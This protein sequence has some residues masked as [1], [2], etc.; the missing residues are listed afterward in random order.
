MRN[1]NKNILSAVDTSSQNGQQVDASQ[2][3]AA[4]FAAYF[5]DASANGTVKI[6]ASNDPAPAREVSAIDGF[7]V[8][9]WVDI[10]NASTTITSGSSALITVSGMA[11]GWIRAVYTRSSG[12][13]TTVNVV[14]NAQGI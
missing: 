13:S 12:G 10:P 9:N 5:G 11:Y 4:S 7:V 1:L 6:Q 2:L 3:Y 14:M 8:T